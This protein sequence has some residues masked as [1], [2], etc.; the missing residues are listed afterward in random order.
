[1]SK[2]VK[3]MLFT[4]ILLTLVLLFSFSTISLGESKA[5][6]SPIVSGEI[7]FTSYDGEEV[8]SFEIGKNYIVNLRNLAPASQWLYFDLKLELDSLVIREDFPSV[9]S[10]LSSYKR[11]SDNNGLILNLCEF[12]PEYA[13]NHNFI[14]KVGVDEDSNFENKLQK[15]F[16]VQNDYEQDSNINMNITFDK[17]VYRPDNDNFTITVNATGG[18]APYNYE[19]ESFD[20][21]LYNYYGNPTLVSSQSLSDTNTYSNVLNKYGFVKVKVMDSTG[22]YNTKTVHFPY[23]FDFEWPNYEQETYIVGGKYTIDFI[24]LSTPGDYV[25]NFVLNKDGIEVDNK[26]SN[27]S[28]TYEFNPENA[29]TY[30]LYVTLINEAGHSVHHNYELNVVTPNLSTNYTV[31]LSYDGFD[32]LSNNVKFNING[33]LTN[34][35]IAYCIYNVDTGTILYDHRDSF[36]SFDTDYEYIYDDPTDDNIWISGTYKAIVYI[37]HNNIIEYTESNEV[38]IDGITDPNSVYAGVSFLEN[39][40]LKGA[41]AV[42]KASVRPDPSLFKYAFVVYKD[43]VLV[44]SADFSDF[45]NFEFKPNEVGEYYAKLKL[46][47]NEGIVNEYQSYDNLTVIEKENAPWNNGTINIVV[48]TSDGNVADSYEVGQEYLVKL[49]NISGNMIGK[50]ISKSAIYCRKTIPLDYP[51]NLIK[52]YD[53]EYLFDTEDL[54]ITNET[55]AQGLFKFKPNFDGE[56]KIGINFFNVEKT[57]NV[58][59]SD[60]SN[61]DLPNSDIVIDIGADKDVFELYD[62]LTITANASGGTAPY[63]YDF[64]LIDV[65][66]NEKFVN[67]TTDVE[68][69]NIAKLIINYPY[70]STNDLY[71][72]VNVKATDSEG[73]FNYEKLRI[74]RTLFF[75]PPYNSRIN[76][77]ET[78]SF[79]IDNVYGGKVVNDNYTYTLD[80][81]KDNSLIS[82][83]DNTTGSFSLAPESPGEYSLKATVR[84]TNGGSYAKSFKL[85]VS[86]I[87]LETESDYFTVR[88][89]KDSYNLGEE[90]FIIPSVDVINKYTGYDIINTETG[91]IVKSLE[92]RFNAGENDKTNS[93]NIPGIYKLRYYIKNGN[94]VNAAESTF[95]VSEAFDVT[96]SADKSTVVSNELVNVTIKAEGG[97]APYKYNVSLAEFWFVNYKDFTLPLNGSVTHTF[98]LSNSA[99]VGN[100]YFVV[101]VT[102]ANGNSVTKRSD[103]IIY[104]PDIYLNLNSNSI[105]LGN[106]ISA[107]TT[108]NAYEVLEENMG[109]EIPYQYQFEIRKGDEL[110]YTQEYSPNKSMYYTPTTSGDYTIIALLKRGDLVLSSA[111]VSFT[112]SQ[113]DFDVQLSVSHTQV[114]PFEESTITATAIGGTEPY[115]YEYTVFN[116]EAPVATQEYSPANTYAFKQDVE[117]DYTIKVKVKD[118][119]N[120]VVEKSTNIKVEQRINIDANLFINNKPA[121]NI[122]VFEKYKKY[123]VSIEYDTSKKGA[124]DYNIK[125]YKDESLIDELNRRIIISANSTYYQNNIYSFTPAETGNYKLIV[126]ISGDDDQYYPISLEKTFSI[127]E[128]DT[129]IQ[130]NLESNKDVITTLE[131]ATIT[132][133]VS[134]GTAPY[135]YQFKEFNENGFSIYESEAS[136]NN[137]FTTKAFHVSSYSSVI[138][139]VTDSLG[140]YNKKEIK[141]PRA[142]NMIPLYFPSNICV[143]EPIEILIGTY[144]G[145]TIDGEYTIIYNLTKDGVLLETNNINNFEWFKYTPNMP[146]SYELTILVTG[147]SGD[148]F[149]STTEF[150]VNDVVLSS[151]FTV[152]VDK[153]QYNKQDEIKI[154]TSP[155]TIDK[156]ISFQLID[157]NTGTIVENQ[158]MYLSNENTYSIYHNVQGTY[159]IRF[160][161]KDGDIYKYA[162]TSNFIIKNSFDVNINLNKNS[163]VNGDTITATVDANGGTAPYSYSLVMLNDTYGAD[164]GY[165]YYDVNYSDSNTL[166]LTFSKYYAIGKY[167]VGAYV[168]DSTGTIVV[169][170][171]KSFS[172]IPPL[173]LSLNKTV[174]APN[175]SI[176]ATATID[177]AETSYYEY[178]YQFE[179]YKDDNLVHTQAYSIQNK[180]NYS[181]TQA[182]NYTVLAKLKYSNNDVLSSESLNFTVE[183]TLNATLNTDKLNYTLG[184]T[185]TAT[186][187]T[188]GGATPYAYEFILSKDN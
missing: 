131:H 52:E 182:G 117:G 16:I 101:T 61:N 123:S 39:T 56:Y 12:I 86:K 178:V 145:I 36:K 54:T 153:Q 43:E 32:A 156:N 183:S 169:A 21:S 143:N 88:T 180:L 53:L 91:E 96:I 4:T 23:D 10:H 62:E 78:Y 119:L 28:S 27:S 170:D 60:S 172:F 9:Y 84:D 77:G 133:N 87:P 175:E 90:I 161:V 148:T 107:K 92:T 70:Y 186:A 40:V 68:M 44:A 35:E 83:Y 109:N 100:N 114:K 95:T 13:G 7:F 80:V 6:A 94:I 85:T 137:V 159:K 98:V 26:T 135:T 50:T 177:A 124:F 11:V 134:G 128:L 46:K 162:E 34:K 113:L 174:L 150:I 171:T 41:S 142:I 122:D 144:G 136:N 106:A 126:T 121:E 130:I 48:L 63:T 181:P 167:I 157:V 163:V 47:D 29:G 187:E 18:I 51:L 79:K 8:D 138:V 188:Q 76:L 165:Y 31:E 158:S 22:K 33:D 38:H 65:L 149:E 129:S 66:D 14:A 140:K 184:N 71:I 179:V 59:A 37:K 104:K 57:I 64:T 75:V 42:V 20:Y 55:I 17:E 160:I 19:F 155:S 97:A 103:S 116:G 132:A 25:F 112:V 111:P 110:V 1:M 125:L 147:E 164:Y 102:D 5:A 127:I 72:T 58:I 3:T 115:T 176:V 81:Y 154:N 24:N 99:F 118:S 173:K 2:S 74:N 139:T 120:A 15:S 69:N 141:I 166:S 152:S 168:K 82:S 45:T 93:G 146:G 89:D 151:D 185:V 49:T 73:K 67:I 108:L 105:V 30:N